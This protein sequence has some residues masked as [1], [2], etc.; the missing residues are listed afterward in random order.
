MKTPKKTTDLQKQIV[1]TT[2]LLNSGRF[3]STSGRSASCKRTPNKEVAKEVK[4]GCYFTN[5]DD[6]LQ[7]VD[8]ETEL[9]LS[10]SSLC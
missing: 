6:D 4:D 9:E 7:M 1:K 10:P 3:K 2:S 8:V 5:K